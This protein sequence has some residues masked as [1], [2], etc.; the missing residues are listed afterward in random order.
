MRLAFLAE[1]KAELQNAEKH[2]VS[3]S[4]SSVSLTDWGDK[5]TL[6]WH[7][8]QQH[9]TP[10]TSAAK[11]KGKSHDDAAGNT[12]GSDNSKSGPQ[13]IDQAAYRVAESSAEADQQFNSVQHTQSQ[14]LAVGNQLQEDPWDA[15]VA[16]PMNIVLPADQYSGKF[17]RLVQQARSNRQ[18]LL[19]AERSTLPMVR[20]FEQGDEVQ[21]TASERVRTED[22][23]GDSGSFYAAR[24]LLTFPSQDWQILFKGVWSA[25]LH[26]RDCLFRWRVI[27]KGFFTG[28]RAALMRVSEGNCFFCGVALED[29][30]HLFF[31]CPRKQDVWD[32]VAQIPV[33]A[34]SVAIIS[35]GGSFP[36]ALKAL[37][38][39]STGR[40]LLLL[41]ILS[42]LLR[43]LWKQRCSLAFEDKFIPLSMTALVSKVSFRLILQYQRVGASRRR[44]LVNVFK[45][46]IRMGAFL[47]Q[48]QFQTIA[49]ILQR[50]TGQ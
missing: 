19:V 35:S 1:F 37:L 47:P 11:E 49:G 48:G 8:K 9:K 34:A 36:V 45:N 44:I 12:V 27:N 31:V 39:L 41:M 50:A 2:P 29:I 46:L 18:A 6:Y 43:A 7:R 20:R 10:E 4:V 42:H 33:L 32:V 3:V 17:K 28:R 15:D 40:R 22:S 30:S 26:R 25:G 23:G 13:N 24:W 14:V 16:Q 38:S 21:H 5:P